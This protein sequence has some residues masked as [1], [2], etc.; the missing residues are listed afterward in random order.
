MVKD[1]TQA[2]PCR[3]QSAPCLPRS[4]VRVLVGSLIL[5][6]ICSFTV[7]VPDSVSGSRTTRTTT[8]G[9][10]GDS[11]PQGQVERTQSFSGDAAG[12]HQAPTWDDFDLQ[13]LETFGVWVSLRGTC[14]WS[15]ESG[16]STLQ[17]QDR[18]SGQLS[19]CWGGALL[20]P[21]RLQSE[22]ALGLWADVSLPVCEVTPIS[23]RL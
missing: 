10:A 14:C 5:S 4:F 9:L 19:V 22:P 21:L 2:Q 11:D 3:P 8:S 1:S 15:V 20:R 6:F 13:S 18:G 7:F 17:A 23:R 16:G 12:S